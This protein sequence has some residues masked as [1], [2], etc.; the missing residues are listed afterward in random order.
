MFI[1]FVYLISVRL[2][3]NIRLYESVQNDTYKEK[4]NNLIKNDDKKINPYDNYKREVCCCLS[5]CYK[6]N[7][8]KIII[9]DIGEIINR[10]AN[11]SIHDE[12]LNVEL[13][14]QMEGTE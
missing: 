4:L 7:N 9:D 10:S 3:D 5:C 14:K 2:I 1:E 8:N 12:Q 6:N 13:I 11:S